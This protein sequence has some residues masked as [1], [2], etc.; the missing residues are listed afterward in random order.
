MISG[1]NGA[2]SLGYTPP[3]PPAHSKPPAKP[4]ASSIE[5]TVH[6]SSAAVTAAGDIDHDGDSK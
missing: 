5:D 1:V 3:T 4:P 6:L 2:S